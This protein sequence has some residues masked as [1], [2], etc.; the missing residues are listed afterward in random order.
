MGDEEQR[1]ARGALFFQC[2]FWAIGDETYGDNI[3]VATFWFKLVEGATYDL[4]LLQATPASLALGVPG[5][6]VYGLVST[7]VQNLLGYV[8]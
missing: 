4:G 8:L 7:S 1:A 3:H 2:N 6:M 5:S